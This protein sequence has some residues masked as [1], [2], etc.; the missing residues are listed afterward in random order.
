MVTFL[1]QATQEV[2]VVQEK[3]QI[4]LVITKL[5]L[6]RR[7]WLLA[8]T[9]KVELDSA[10]EGEE[11]TEQIDNEIAASP[12]GSSQRRYLLLMILRIKIMCSLGYQ[13]L[14]TGTFFVPTRL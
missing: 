10:F 4:N 8:K 11:E 7:L 14:T 12:N 3:L 6:P 1:G 2:P 9:I 13:K 5:R